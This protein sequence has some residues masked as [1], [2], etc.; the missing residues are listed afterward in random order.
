MKHMIRGG[1][2]PGII[3]KT[4]EEFDIN[5]RFGVT[6][7][8]FRRN[9]TTTTIPHGETAIEPGDELIILASDEHLEEL[10]DF[11]SGECIGGPDP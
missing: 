6:L 7:L 1:L 11:L 8:A 9:M 2:N 4:I 5:T 3:G 10:S